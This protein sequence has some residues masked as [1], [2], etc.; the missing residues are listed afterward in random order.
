MKQTSSVQIFWSQCKTRITDEEKSLNHGS[1]SYQSI[2]VG[3]ECRKH[4]L[5]TRIVFCKNNKLFDRYF[6]LCDQPVP[7]LKMDT[8]VQSCLKHNC[9]LWLEVSYQGSII[10]K[11]LRREDLTIEKRKKNSNQMQ[12]RFTTANCTSKSAN[13]YCN[14]GEIQHH[15]CNMSVKHRAVIKQTQAPL[16]QTVSP[17]FCQTERPL[18]WLDLC[19]NVYLFYF[20]SVFV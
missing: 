20:Q 15:F 7:V 19:Q 2:R 11:R 13:R 18:H 3:S 5:E 4:G 10:D 17:G 9:F 12:A 16:R 8:F 1:V 6:A 14:L